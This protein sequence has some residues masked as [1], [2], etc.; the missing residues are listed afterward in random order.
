MFMA[1]DIMLDDR[2]LYS[3][4]RVC[5]KLGALAMVHAENGHMI[6]QVRVATFHGERF[7]AH[8]HRCVVTVNM[9]LNNVL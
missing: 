2:E 7:D 1:F 6:E 8:F 3:A 5:K 9:K 4:F